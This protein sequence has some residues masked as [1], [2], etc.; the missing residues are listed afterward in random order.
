MKSSRKYLLGI[1]LIVFSALALANAVG[2]IMPATIFDSFPCSNEHF[3]NAD[4][5]SDTRMVY[6]I[7]LLPLKAISGIGVYAYDT[8]NQDQ[9]VVREL[10]LK[11]EG[12]TLYVNNH[13]LNVGE[14]YKKVLWKPS[15][16]PWLIFTTRFSIKHIEIE[17][18]ESPTSTNM[19]YVGGDVHEGWLPNPLGLVILGCGIWLYKQG[20]RERKQIA[21]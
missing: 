18:A 7:S 12:Q 2:Q 1:V 20:K 11:R 16:N 17:L 5:S 3:R 6:C 14:V 8:T 4:V 21:I 10:N 9:I 19:L 13:A 15:I